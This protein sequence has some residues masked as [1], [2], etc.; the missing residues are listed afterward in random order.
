MTYLRDIDLA[1]RYGIHRV[2][3]WKWVKEGRFPAP[4]R[5]A[6]S[7]TRWRASD[8]EAWEANAINQAA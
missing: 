2:T 7:T 1:R 5:L 3:V 8:V 6:P 4:V